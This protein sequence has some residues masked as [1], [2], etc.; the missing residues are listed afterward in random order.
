MVST[1]WS[2]SFLQ[3]FYSRCPPSSA[4]CKSR[5]HVSSVPYGVGATASD[6]LRVTTR[7][8]AVYE[9]FSQSNQ[10]YLLKFT[11]T[12]TI[13]QVIH[14]AGQQGSTSGTDYCR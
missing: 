14:Q 1:V 7:L 4:I 3:L 8:F 11:G 2:V 10:I 5:G 12:M 13:T 9:W 6:N